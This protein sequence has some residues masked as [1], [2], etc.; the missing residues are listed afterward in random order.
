[1]KPG[2]WSKT[3]LTGIFMAQKCTIILVNATNITIRV[4][5]CCGFDCCYTDL[6]LIEKWLVFN[7]FCFQI[8]LYLLYYYVFTP[9]DS[10]VQAET[11]E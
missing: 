11:P 6:T 1:M 8:D 9:N 7:P 5:V 3:R 10:N 2:C 4:Q